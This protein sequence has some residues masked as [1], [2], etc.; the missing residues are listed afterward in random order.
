MKLT[1]DWQKAAK[2][3]SGL[4]AR[5][6]K[7]VAQAVAQEAQQIRGDIVKGIRSGAPAGKA[8]APLSAMTLAVRKFRGGGGTKPLIQSGAL[9]GGITALKV[10]G[11]WFVG[12]LRR[13]KGKGGKS[14]ANIGAI[15]EYGASWTQALTP[16]AR[17]FL[18]AVLRSSGLAGPSPK[19][20]KPSAGS[21][22]EG[23]AAAAAE[24]KGTGNAGAPG[25]ITIT[26]PARPFIGPVI[27]KARAGLAKR[28]WERVAKEMGGD[29]GTP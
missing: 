28:F 27:E 10:G 2:I 18:F 11:G 26:I 12:L 6:K 24:G 25:T 16:K 8:F 20:A 23:K 1:G 21:S 29:L 5:W 15:H 3:A 19:G 22:P 14:L 4:E 9:I 7:A 17:R 13:G